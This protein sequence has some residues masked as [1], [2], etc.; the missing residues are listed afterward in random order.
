MKAFLVALV[1]LTVLL[2]L[3]VATSPTRPP[4]PIRPVEGDE[5]KIPQQIDRT[6][7]KPLILLYPYPGILIPQRPMLPPSM[8]PPSM[9]PP[10]MLPPM[11][12]PFELVTP[13]P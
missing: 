10:S 2:N 6:M 4:P 7:I 9:L 3:A 1:C 8:L 5:P 12:I 11:R 13:A